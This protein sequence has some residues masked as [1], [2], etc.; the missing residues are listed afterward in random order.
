MGSALA[1]SA[2]SA[3]VS[4]QQPH[5]E[6]SIGEISGAVHQAQSSSTRATDDPGGDI[7]VELVVCAVV[8]RKTSW[9]VDY[10]PIKVSDRARNCKPHE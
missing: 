9:Q 4:A 3:L 6:G 2:Y 5:S 1:V 7:H 10:L 8:H